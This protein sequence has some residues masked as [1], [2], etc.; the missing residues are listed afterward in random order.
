MTQQLRVKWRNVYL[1][2]DGWDVLNVT[3]TITR[4][5][6][7]ASSFDQTVYLLLMAGF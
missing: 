5:N 2:P 7:F 6:V 1:I 4:K 3:R